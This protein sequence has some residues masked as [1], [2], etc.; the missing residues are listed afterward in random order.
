MTG[1]EWLSR[2]A[3]TA[4]AAAAAIIQHSKTIMESSEISKAVTAHRII[5]LFF[6]VKSSQAN[7]E[8]MLAIDIYTPFP[9]L[10]PGRCR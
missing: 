2:V 6:R 5:H 9:V 8:D 1:D 7:R 4:V 10:F 3:V